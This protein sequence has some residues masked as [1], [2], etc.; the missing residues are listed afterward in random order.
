MPLKRLPTPN[1]GSA[2]A[3]AT[4]PATVPIETR[5]TLADEEGADGEEIDEIE[6][7]GVLQHGNALRLEAANPERK[8]SRGS[9]GTGVELAPTGI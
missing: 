2:A 5:L 3:R 7:R 8:S 9:P 1:V 6:L 4:S